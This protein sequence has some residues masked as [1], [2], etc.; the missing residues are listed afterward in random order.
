MKFPGTSNNFP[1]EVAIIKSIVQMRELRLREEGLSWAT[2]GSTVELILRQRYLDV[3]LCW[4]NSALGL[5]GF[6]RM[7]TGHPSF[8]ANTWRSLSL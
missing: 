3:R 4:G 2:Q 7:V 1:C 5:Q 8:P 6:L